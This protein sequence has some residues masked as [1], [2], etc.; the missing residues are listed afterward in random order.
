MATP[1]PSASRRE[2]IKV[3]R[4]RAAIQQAAGD[5][6]NTLLGY[7]SCVVSDPAPVDATAAMIGAHVAL[8]GS[9][10]SFDIALVASPAG[11]LG[12]AQAI[13]QAGDSPV[14]DKDIA[15]AVSELVNMMAGTIKRHLASDSEIG[16]PMF[17][18][19]SI[20]PTDRLT[21]T[22]FP[23]KLGPVQAYVLIA[24]E[25]GSIG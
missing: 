3:Q 23:V 18:R 13:L 2:P 4:V 9:S 20:Q 25:R 11:C 5:L 1:L 7:A 21:V 6:A 15:D 8:V 10:Q 19:G 22:A 16:L 14:K 12:L 17:I 24:G